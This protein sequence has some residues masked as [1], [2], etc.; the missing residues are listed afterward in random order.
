[1][2][3]AIVDDQKSDRE[4]L[5]S[6]IQEYGAAAAEAMTYSAYASSEAFLDAFR[7]GK[8]SAVFLDIL[9]S[10]MSGLDAAREI[11]KKDAHIAI[12]FTT[13]EAGFALE[14]YDIH[15]LDYL[16][17]PVTA[18][19][20]AWCLKKLYDIAAVPLY[21]KVRGTNSAGAPAT[22]RML[23]LEDILFAE[24]IHNGVMIHTT[25]GDIRTSYTFREFMQLLPGTGQFFECSRGIMVNF[26]HVACILENGTISLG[27]SSDIYCSRRKTKETL[28][29]YA[30][31]KFTQLRKGI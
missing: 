9:M 7:P 30:D 20:L 2:Y 3:F 15:A 13:T 19:R 22:V 31:Y 6:L 10:G 16:V 5:V 12:I 11:R 26:M 24:S 21:I 8:F 1:M 17:K 18:E 14:S 27:N 23:P 4:H 25:A 29:A 28:N